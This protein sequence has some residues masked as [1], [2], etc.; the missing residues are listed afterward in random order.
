M[1]F[2][3]CTQAICVL[4]QLSDARHE[5]RPSNRTWAGEEQGDEGLVGVGADAVGVRLPLGARSL[6]VV[7]HHKHAVIVRVVGVGR[8]RASGKS[9]VGIKP[10]TTER[11]RPLI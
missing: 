5:S 11:A 2:L 9:N 6:G 1:G 8:L 7:V 10:K 3:P 4:Q